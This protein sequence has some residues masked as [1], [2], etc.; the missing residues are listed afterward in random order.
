MGSRADAEDLLQDA[1][2]KGLTRG[3]QLEDAESA[4]A[5]FYCV[6]RNALTEPVPSIV[7]GMVWGDTR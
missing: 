2:V 5:W 1:V 3:H 4:I 6:L 7:T